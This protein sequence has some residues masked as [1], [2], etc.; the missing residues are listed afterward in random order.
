MAAG[1]FLVNERFSRSSNRDS[2]V[3]GTRAFFLFP[4]PRWLKLEPQAQSGVVTVRLDPVR[5]VEIGRSGF[6]SRMT[7]AVIEEAP[8]ITQWGNVLLDACA[9]LGVRSNVSV[10]PGRAIV[11]AA[12]M[13]SFLVTRSGMTR[14]SS[15]SAR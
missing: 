8:A 4:R 1:Q 5:V 6:I 13:A 12:A 9:A 10:E 11:A 3:S 14:S 15:P 2:A 7:G